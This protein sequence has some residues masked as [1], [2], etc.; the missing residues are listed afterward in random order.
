LSCIISLFPGSWRRIRWK[1]M[2]IG[3]AQEV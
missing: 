3:K 2:W 1:E